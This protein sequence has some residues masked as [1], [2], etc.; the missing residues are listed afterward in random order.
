MWRAPRWLYGSLVATAGLAGCATPA[1]NAPH[2]ASSS[3]LA[4][5][6][7]AV[8]RGSVEAN[9]RTLPAL[10]DGPPSPDVRPAPTY[11]ALT[12]SECQCLA[13][14]AVVPARLQA[15]ETGLVRGNGAALR[16]AVLAYTAQELRNRAA[17]AALEIYY[18]IAEAEGKADL[19]SQ[20]VTQLDRMVRETRDMAAQKLKPPVALDVWTRQ[21]LT[22]QSDQV[23]ADM[24]L[25]Q[26]NSELR[27]L[28]GLRDCGD[29]W[30]V[31]NPDK[32]D[33]TDS[34]FNVDAAVAEGLARRPE[35]LLLRVLIQQLGA[36]NLPAARD[37]L[38]SVHPLLGAARHPVLTKI[39]TILHLP[40][41]N[42][43]ELATRRQQLAEYLVEREAAVA[44]EIRQAAAGIQSHAR[45][46]AL[47]WARERIWEEKVKDVESRKQ[48]GLAPSAE[49]TSTTLE[50]LKA[51]GEVIQEAM[52]WHIARVKLSQAQG[53]LW[54]GEVA[55]W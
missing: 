33:V 42:G 50:M 51:R 8:P 24:T 17:G 13:A 35:L 49:V 27:H 28:L 2:G 43:A 36:G 23:Q 53:L 3:P 10:P 45:L 55:K 44:D 31:W 29:P 15:A 16:Q 7:P 18:H 34:P 32:Y 48:Q 25:T 21:L 46:T 26:L 20:G 41:E 12:A 1:P 52:A 47:A 5:T 22:M 30:R 4:T 39:V 11:R 9:L 6:L 54:G 38:R 37:L 40:I 14:A 19:L